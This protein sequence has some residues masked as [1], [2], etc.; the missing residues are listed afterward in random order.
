MENEIEVIVRALES[1]NRVFIIRG[2]AGTG[3][4][5]LVKRLALLLPQLKRNGGGLIELEEA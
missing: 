5:T 4:T 2:A 1:G 3:K